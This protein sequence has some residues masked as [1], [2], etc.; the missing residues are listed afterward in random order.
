MPRDYLPARRAGRGR[1]QEVRVGC[2]SLEIIRHATIEELP[3][4]NQPRQGGT[5]NVC[6]LNAH[7]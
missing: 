7:I 3:K 4:A 5:D 6:A 2:V 1:V